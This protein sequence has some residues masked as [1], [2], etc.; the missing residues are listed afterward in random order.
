[1]LAPTGTKGAVVE[2]ETLRAAL[3]AGLGEKPS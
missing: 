3:G 1:V 2:A